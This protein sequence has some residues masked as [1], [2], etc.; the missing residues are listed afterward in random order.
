MAYIAGIVLVMF[1]I[2]GDEDLPGVLMPIAVL[3]VLVLSVLVM[4][5]LFLYDPVRLLIEGRREEALRWFWKSVLPFA[6]MVALFLAASF[7][8]TR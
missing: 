5:Y 7:A 4:T 6:A 3:S 1:A 2:A 8:V